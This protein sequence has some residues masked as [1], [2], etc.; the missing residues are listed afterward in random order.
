MTD[1]VSDICL[2]MVRDHDRARYLTTLYAPAA[3]RQDLW[4][5]HAFNIELSRIGD[6]VSEPMIGEIRLAWWRE[7]IDAL[8][9]G[10]VRKH[11]VVEAMG[12]LPARVPKSLLDQMIDART[13]DVYHNQPETMGDLLEYAH[14]TGGA[15][16][17]A[18]AHILTNPSEKSI[19]ESQNLGAAWALVSL[20]RAI[21]FHLKHERNF[22]P[23]AALQDAG[24]PKETLFQQAI[25]P[26]LI[27][28]IRKIAEK[29][30][31]L[32]ST[33]ERRTQ[34]HL[35]LAIICRDYLKRLANANHDIRHVDFNRG[36]VSRQLK[37]FAAG[38]MGWG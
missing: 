11:P 15:Q 9:S 30:D 37:L 33:I 16:Q 25:G 7:T 34:P 6:I 38:V 20:I 35:L 26:E 5:L 2:N 36:D 23:L 19:H 10:T 24:L 18:T 12:R 28:V 14:N 27:P 22:L 31:E 32:L 21:P 3:A 17:K 13:R 29:A 8:Y 1:S 4:A